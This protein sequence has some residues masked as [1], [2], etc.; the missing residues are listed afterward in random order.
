[1]LLSGLIAAIL[2]Y[3]MS[4][5]PAIKKFP[6]L[7]AFII[8]I[9]IGVVVLAGVCC[10]SNTSASTSNQL[11]ALFWVVGGLAA[12]FLPWHTSPLILMVWR[13]NSN[14]PIQTT[15]VLRIPDDWRR[16]LLAA[17]KVY[18]TARLEHTQTLTIN[19]HLSSWEWVKPQ[20]RLKIFGKSNKQLEEDKPIVEIFTQPD[21][22]A[23]LLI[24][25]EPG[26]GKTTM[27]LK[28]ALNLIER[29]QRDINLP[30]PVLFEL[31]NAQDDKQNIADWL[32][33]D[34][35]FRYNVPEYISCQWLDTD[36]LL[37]LLDGLDE[38][39]LARQKKCLDKI[40]DFLQNNS[41][42]LPIVIC[43][44]QEQYIKGKKI[45]EKLRGAVY[46]Q[47]LTQTQIKNYLQRLECF[48]LW[49]TIKSDNDGW[50]KLA[51][52]PFFLRLL[53]LAY[54]ERLVTKTE[55]GN[56]PAERLAYLEKC[57]QE[58]F[59]AYIQRRLGEHHDRQGYKIQ[60]TKRWLIWLAKT[61]EEQNL[62]E[63]YIENMQPFCLQTTPQKWLYFMLWTHLA[64]LTSG[65]IL[66]L[67][68]YLAYLSNNNLTFLSVMFV[69]G[70]V[71]FGW[72]I[73][74]Y[75]PA[76][77]SLFT[78]FISSFFG[79][80]NTLSSS[81]I[82]PKFIQ[83]NEPIKWQTININNGIKRII[84]FYS[85]QYNRHHNWLYKALSILVIP[86]TFLVLSS[87][88]THEI[89][90]K[91]Q[92]NQGIKAS[93]KNALIITLIGSLP[94]IL[95][96]TLFPITMG[97]NAAVNMM[98]IFV[99]LI[100]LLF[101]SIYG[102]QACIQ[103]L[104]LRIT[105]WCNDEIPWNYARFLKYANERKLIQQIGGRYQ[106]IHHLLQQ[107]VANMP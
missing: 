13:G 33:A 59:D 51:K 18:V 105:L 49:Q 38:L 101:A 22:A 20:M 68:G 55:R 8:K 88:Q 95:I 35:K 102:G 47:P 2:G 81:D 54:P 98:L 60:D 11:P 3:F 89:I 34:L 70:L 78:G 90:T 37:P 24:L 63:F 93:G 76:I 16:E 69:P 23:R 97:N 46:L 15:P 28:L 5:L 75:I 53:T 87:I 21:I 71:S 45:L 94:W 52:I 44:R 83:Q 42:L 103:H 100:G 80:N 25:G 107:H 39:K 91:N 74:F 48:S 9:T 27:L 79:D 56:S 36:K 99:E 62:P 50:G 17:M 57:R 64:S 43:C 72:L 1:M 26:S 104:A 32:I 40:N 10:L 86:S 106:F 31:A 67:T 7:S 61:I 29:A 92:P 73:Y 66:G 30:I 77:F 14:Q 85:Q 6:A 82:Y 12:L 58:L 96:Y 19:N 65:L 84:F 4:Q 41:S